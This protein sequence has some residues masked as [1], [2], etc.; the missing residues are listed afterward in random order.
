MK[1]RVAALPPRAYC[2]P[3]VC[4][5]CYTQLVISIIIPAFNEAEQ[6]PG[7]L[8]SIAAQGVA[9]EIIV[10][11]AHSTDATASISQGFGAHLLESGRRQRGAQ[12]N[13]GARAA[14]GEVLLFLHADTRLAP[15][16][17]ANLET[18]LAQRIV[19][20]GGFARRYDIPSPLLR[21]TCALAELR[22]RCFGWFLGDQAMF[23]RRSVFQQLGG[24]RE[25]DSFEDLDFSRR[26]ARAGR[27]VTLR[28]P[29]VSAARRF[30][31]Q[32][33]LR[34]TWRDLCLTARYL[35]HGSGHTP[36][37][38]AEPSPIHDSRSHYG[39]RPV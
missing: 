25:W 8:A 19:L 15:G 14:H 28:P 31:T 29:V 24:F 18:A 38:P 3:R 32:G 36:R 5:L 6:L 11:D 10:V 12:M 9:L 23:V 30:A 22:T 7:T 27:V 37:R 33:P 13:A 35:T 1:R 2:F 21:G 39:H 26:L 16:S 4:H 17:L 34:T 20:G